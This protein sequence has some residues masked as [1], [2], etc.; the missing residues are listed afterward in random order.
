MAPTTPAGG[1]TAS[2]PAT[3]RKGVRASP[4]GGGAPAPPGRGRGVGRQEDAVGQ[5]VLDRD[6]E[7]ARAVVGAQRGA[8][9]AVND[10]Q[11]AVA[12]GGVDELLVGREE[13]GRVLVAPQ[14]RAAGPADAV[15]AGAVDGH[16]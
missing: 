11:A 9:V 1:A 8:P 6:D 16:V 4:R 15:E 5:V 10:E 14:L 13:A 2:G 12:V 3:S 7:V